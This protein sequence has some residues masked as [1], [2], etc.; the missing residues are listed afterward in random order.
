[1][2]RKELIVE[3]VAGL[4][5]ILECALSS[6][7]FSDI[8]HGPMPPESVPVKDAIDG[9]YDKS[10]LGQRFTFLGQLDCHPTTEINPNVP[11]MDFYLRATDAVDTNLRI[12]V[13]PSDVNYANQLAQYCNGPF[14]INVN[15]ELSDDKTKI[16]HAISFGPAQII[17]T[18]PK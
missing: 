9:T 8:I 7:V 3:A 5:I 16:N 11:H 14:T 12:T 6:S 17:S 15:G 10:I 2:R 13:V 4:G 18:D 1:M